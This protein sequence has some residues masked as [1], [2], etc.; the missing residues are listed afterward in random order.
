MLHAKCYGKIQ[1]NHILTQHI[2]RRKKHSYEQQARQHIPPFLTQCLLI[3]EE[4]PRLFLAVRQSSWIFL[5]LC[6]CGYVK[7]VWQLHISQRRCGSLWCL[8]KDKNIIE[9][10]RGRK[11]CPLKR[12]LSSLIV[13]KH[14]RINKILVRKLIHSSRYTDSLSHQQFCRA[15]R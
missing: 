13:Q 6:L 5:S 8:G 2:S 10:V 3:V 14:Y 1:N 12:S 7:F 11:T 4:Y 15:S 9:C